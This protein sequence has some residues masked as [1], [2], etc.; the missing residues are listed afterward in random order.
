MKAAA[1]LALLLAAAGTAARSADVTDN[2]PVKI[3]QINYN[4]EATTEICLENGFPDVQTIE[5]FVTVEVNGKQELTP[6]KLNA[7]TQSKTCALFDAP[8]PGNGQDVEYLVAFTKDDKENTD[9]AKF[10]FE[11]S[12]GVETF[13]CG[14]DAKFTITPDVSDTD[15]CLNADADASKLCFELDDS[16]R[17]KQTGPDCKTPDSKDFEYCQ[18]A[19]DE[20]EIPTD[21]ATT[22][23]V[24]GLSY[25]DPAALILESNLYEGSYAVVL[26]SVTSNEPQVVKVTST[27]NIL[28]TSFTESTS[29][30]TTCV[31]VK[32]ATP[33]EDTVTSPG[34]I[35]DLDVK[36]DVID[37]SNAKYYEFGFMHAT[38]TSM[39]HAK[40]GATKEVM[41]NCGNL[42]AGVDRCFGY[43]VRENDGDKLT[44]SFKDDTN[45]ITVDHSL[46]NW[47]FDN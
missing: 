7:L 45:T 10:T 12:T 19:A 5:L 21:Q 31:V 13:S 24:S 37:E 14:N 28:I 23:T 40:S 39:Y 25:I 43:L 27:N 1:L 15:I 47:P 32:G 11:E 16:S 36:V 33:T 20:H 9:A 35:T 34:S 22:A 26:N 6:Y 44:I 18:T 46:N 3:T 8:R 17:E 42:A 30:Y 2:T 38:G 41:V 4:D 29:T